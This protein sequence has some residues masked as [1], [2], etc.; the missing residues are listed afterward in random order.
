MDES[1][2]LTPELRELIWDT[3]AEVIADPESAGSVARA[4]APGYLVTL[5]ETPDG[6]PIGTLIDVIEYFQLGGEGP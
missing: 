5:T 2:I 1:T 6:A 4:G 3:L